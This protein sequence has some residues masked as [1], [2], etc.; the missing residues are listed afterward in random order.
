MWRLIHGPWSGVHVFLNPDQSNE[1]NHDPQLLR[2]H[3]NKT[4]SL[5]DQMGGNYAGAGKIDNASCRARVWCFLTR[6]SLAAIPRWQI[7]SVRLQSLAS[8]ALYPLFPCCPWASNLCSLQ[9]G[10]LAA[11][12]PSKQQRNHVV[13]THDFLYTHPLGFLVFSDLS[14]YVGFV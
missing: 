1:R 5:W 8:G 7:A 12:T 14:T 2:L 3:S 9:F 13:T 11:Q 6:R 4:I 10:P